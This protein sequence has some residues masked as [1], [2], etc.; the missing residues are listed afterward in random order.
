[1]PSPSRSSWSGFGTKAQLSFAS[2]TRSPSVSPP[3]PAR[4]KPP[5]QVSGWLQV[6]PF[7]L[8]TV[9][10]ATGCASQ[11]PSG[12]MQAPCRHTSSRFEQST[13]V[14]ATQPSFTSQVSTPL[15]AR[16]SSQ[17]VHT[18]QVVFTV[19]GGKTFT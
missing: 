10:S 18:A 14:P 2:H 13:A 15:Q 11:W 19:S 16:W 17:L 3:P 4:Q 5:W 1:M 9:P 6:S 8:H 7:A 12:S